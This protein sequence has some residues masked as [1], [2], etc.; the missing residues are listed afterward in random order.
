MANYKNMMDKWKDWRLDE[1]TVENETN[2]P[3]QVMG[4]RN[5]DIVIKGNNDKYISNIWKLLPRLV[6]HVFEQGKQLARLLLHLPFLRLGRDATRADSRLYHFQS[7][8]CDLDFEG[9]FRQCTL[10]H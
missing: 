3:F 9:L 10:R 7:A 2:L 8:V 6:W 1:A 5:N 4:I